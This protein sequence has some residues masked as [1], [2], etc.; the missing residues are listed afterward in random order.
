MP[1]EEALV[2]LLRLLHYNMEWE[3]PHILR[4]GNREAIHTLFSLLIHKT[5]IMLH[6]NTS[7]SLF[8]IC[9]IYD[10]YILS[11][12]GTQDLPLLSSHRS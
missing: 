5:C 8:F 7:V 2:F 10:K 11:R 6:A 3:N 12:Y 9:S 4:T 1:P